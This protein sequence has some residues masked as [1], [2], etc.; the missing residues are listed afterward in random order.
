VALRLGL[1]EEGE[2]RACFGAAQWGLGGDWGRG[3]VRQGEATGRLCGGVKRGTTR[4][5][6]PC[7]RGG[8]RVR[9]AVRAG[10]TATG[11]AC[12]ARAGRAVRR[13]LLSNTWR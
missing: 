11:Q 9:G 1:R 5:E 10:A 4:S 3:A 7:S 8:A 6:F 2:S 12:A 13:R